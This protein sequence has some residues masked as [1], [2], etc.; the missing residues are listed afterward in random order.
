VNWAGQVL[1]SL[2]K[3]PATTV[4]LFFNAELVMDGTW[5]FPILMIAAMIAVFLGHAFKE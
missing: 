5:I 4:G 1:R 3:S 2:Y